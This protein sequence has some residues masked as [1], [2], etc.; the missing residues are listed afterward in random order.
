[1]SYISFDPWRQVQVAEVPLMSDGQLEEI[2][3]KAG[4]AF[5]AWRRMPPEERC[6]PLT[7]MAELL[8][9]HSGDLATVISSEMGKPV[10]QGIAEVEKCATLCRW[11]A[12]HAPHLLEPERRISSARTSLVV[13]EP[14]GITLGI[15]PWNFPFWQVFRFIVPA[16]AGGNAALLKHASSV[17][18]CALEIEKTVKEAGF[19]EGLFRTIFPSHS[20]VERLIADSR[21]RGVSLTGSTDAGRRIASVAGTHL[22]K[23]VMELGGSDPFIVFPDADMDSAVKAAV[24]SRFQNGGQSCIAAKRIIVHADAYSEFRDKFVSAV[25]ALRTGD[26]LD[27]LTDVGPVVNVAAAD[28]LM[29]Q[30]TGTLVSGAKL[31]CGGR[32]GKEHPALFFPAVIDD[33]PPDSPLVCEETFGPAAPLIRFREAEE[34]VALANGTPYGLGA[35]VWTEDKDLA[36]NIA[37]AIDTGTVAINGFVKSEPGLPFGGVKESGYGRELAGEGLFEFL[38]TKTISIF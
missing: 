9:Q 33:V 32:A 38:N 2:A 29:R 31:L 27:P 6:R 22:K 10:T 17:P 37:R 26:P 35:S 14:Q 1:M 5:R 7:V 36:M 30:L 11:Y 3:C 4:D 21:I 8:H 24:S 20:Q 23:V 18:R 12:G 34:A 25:K 16:F 19:P 15:M 13:R 28:E